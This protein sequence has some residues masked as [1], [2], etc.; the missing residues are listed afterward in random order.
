[1]GE[2][3]EV[4]VVERLWRASVARDERKNPIAAAAMVKSV[5]SG[6]L[7]T[8]RGKGGNPRLKEILP[9]TYLSIST[10]S[11]RSGCRRREESMRNCG[12]VMAAA[13]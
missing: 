11:S 9:K 10:R 6:G 4:V 3:E 8:R 5:H 12:P 13:R 1:M 7:L 2:E